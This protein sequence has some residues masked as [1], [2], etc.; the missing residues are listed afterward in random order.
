MVLSNKA[1]EIKRMRDYAFIVTFL[2]LNDTLCLSW[3][4]FLLHNF[5]LIKRRAKISGGWLLIFNV[6]MKSSIRPSQLPLKTSYRGISSDQMVLTTNAMNELRTQMFFTQLRFYCSK[7][8]GRTFHV[9]TAAN[10]S[11][12]AVVQYFSGQTDVQPASCGSFVTMENDNSKLAGDCRMWVNS[13][14]GGNDLYHQ[15]II[16][17]GAYHWR[18]TPPFDGRND[19]DDYGVGV[20]SGDFWKVFVR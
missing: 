11:G 3:F 12:E 10:S 4:S 20:S 13:K 1:T 16:V 15:P 9:T 6:T 2:F 14:W 17:Y 7:K 5:K 18:L 19:C 8:Q